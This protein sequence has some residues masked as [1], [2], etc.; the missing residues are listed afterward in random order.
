MTGSDQ[1]IQSGVLAFPIADDISPASA[2]PGIL[3][4]AGFPVTVGGS[5]GVAFSIYANL[6]GLA[7][8]DD[9]S[10]YF[11]QVDLT[12]FS[13]VTLSKSHQ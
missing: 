3:S 11:Q 10:V 1:L 12:N 7:V 2:P 4:E 9:G 5:F 8:D 13:G 6:A